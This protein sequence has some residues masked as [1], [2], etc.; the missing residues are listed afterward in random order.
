ME[1]PNFR[2]VMPMVVES[3]G[4]GER[5][6]D[7][8][9]LLLKER[10]IFLGTPI[11]DQVA[12]LIVAQLLY[13]NYEDKR[14]DIQLYINSPGGAIHAGLA[15][16][17][18]DPKDA[19]ERE[20][21]ACLQQAPDFLPAYR[22]LAKLRRATPGRRSIRSVPRAGPG[23][24]RGSS[25]RVPRARWQPGRRRR[26]SPGCPRWQTA[27]RHRRRS[28]RRRSVDRAAPRRSRLPPR[29][30][31]RS[32][33]AVRARGGPS[34]HG[35]PRG[36]ALAVAPPRGPRAPTGHTTERSR[37]SRGC[38][39]SRSALQRRVGRRTRHAYAGRGR[40]VRRDRRGALRSEPGRRV[41]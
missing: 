1:T 25:I 14:R 8:Y 31:R 16:S 15:I 39:G 29:G 6:Y 33:R 2:S 5:A 11:N 30:P 40:A 20:L 18:L 26:S 4:R 23:A 17:R 32:G 34:P 24:G 13:L 37:P 19:A 12:N 27:D 21:E 9:S 35:P 3:S 7:I 41:R 38:A 10:I 28:P 22:S 36:R